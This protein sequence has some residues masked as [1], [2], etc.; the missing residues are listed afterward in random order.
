MARLAIKQ[1]LRHQRFT[2]N[3]DGLLDCF[4]LA[5]RF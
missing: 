5:E 4:D 3:A 2:G 1:A